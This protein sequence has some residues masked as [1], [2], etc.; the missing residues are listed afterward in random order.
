MQ[1]TQWSVWRE[2]MLALASANFGR[3]KARLV[4]TLAL[5]VDVLSTH[6]LI[7]HRDHIP[8]VSTN[9]SLFILVLIR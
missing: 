9:I 5:A 8:V 6:I 7:M 1:T 4:V 2:D 3:S